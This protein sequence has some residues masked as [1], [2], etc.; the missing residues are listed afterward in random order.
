MYDVNSN[1]YFRQLVALTR[2]CST[3]CSA[4]HMSLLTSLPPLCFPE[5]ASHEDDS[6]TAT[7]CIAS[8]AADMTPMSLV[9]NT[10][11]N[12][13]IHCHKQGLAVTCGRLCSIE[14]RGGLTRAAMHAVAAHQACQHYSMGSCGQIRSGNR[15]AFLAL[16]VTGCGCSRIV[17]RGQSEPPTV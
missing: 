8:A 2:P 5:Q 1:H 13:C 12:I 3:S 6:T 10:S 16:L 14:W 4:M 15:T 11:H 7:T 9:H 17:S